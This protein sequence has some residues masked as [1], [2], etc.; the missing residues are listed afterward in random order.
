MSEAFKDIE[1][2]IAA[3]K[4]YV[5]P[6]EDLRA[7]TLELARDFESSQQ[8]MRSLHRFVLAIGLLMLVVIP[9]MDRIV[10]FPVPQGPSSAEMVNRAN[11]LASEA[12]VGKQWGMVEAFSRLQQTRANPHQF[13]GSSQFSGTNRF[14]G[15]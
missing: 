5:Q 12:S 9:M 6:S 13:S 1:T 3:A 10:D 7:R 14:P 15:N 4:H 2:L 8:A 11:I